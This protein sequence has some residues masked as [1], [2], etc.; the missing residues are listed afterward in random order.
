MGPGW[1]GT[2]GEACA[3]SSKLTL[4]AEPNSLLFRPSRVAP[5]RIVA[6]FA[7]PVT[8]EVAGSSPVAPVSAH[9]VAVQDLT[10]ISPRRALVPA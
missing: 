3:K 4:D 8:P 9:H 1:D 5:W 7:R 2:A 10:P 6:A